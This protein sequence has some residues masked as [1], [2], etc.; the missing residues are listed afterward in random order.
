MTEPER[1]HTKGMDDDK[2]PPPVRRRLKADD[3]I[4][5]S[6]KEGMARMVEA[7]RR[8]SS[9]A[10]GIEGPPKKAGLGKYVVTD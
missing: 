1:D 2:A 8:Y 6:G 7:L 10:F 3:L 5:E 9:Q 4:L